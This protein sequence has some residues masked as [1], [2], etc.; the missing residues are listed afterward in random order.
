M[1]NED[2]P[3]VAK[4]DRRAAAIEATIEERTRA[5]CDQAD[6]LLEWLADRNLGLIDIRVQ[7]PV[8]LD[9]MDADV[10]LVHAA[11]FGTSAGWVM[12]QIEKWLVA[13][14][15]MRKHA[16]VLAMPREE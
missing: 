10:A 9:S 1:I 3:I 8:T 15:E 11:I 4:R 16:E 7:H 6:D 13:S 14:D 5:L 2:D 12:D